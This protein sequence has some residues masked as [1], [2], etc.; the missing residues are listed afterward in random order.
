MPAPRSNFNNQKNSFAT[1]H[2]SSQP[3]CHNCKKASHIARNCTL[4]PAAIPQDTPTT[5]CNYCKE[6]G[7]STRNCTS[8]TSR[9]M[10]RLNANG[11]TRFNGSSRF[12]ATPVLYAEALPSAPSQSI[13]LS[14][15]SS[16]SHDQLVVMTNW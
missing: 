14:D 8:P 7:H 1:Q 16:P 4:P 12:S 11:T 13:V 6:V 2:D 5:Q 15:T 3:F 9:N 10:R